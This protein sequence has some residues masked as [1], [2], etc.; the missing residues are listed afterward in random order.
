[1][2]KDI[3]WSG[4]VWVGECFFWC[5]LIWV[6]P[7]KWLLNS[8]VFV[9]FQLWTH[10]CFYGTGSPVFRVNLVCPANNARAL[11][12]TQNTDPISG[13][14]DLSLWIFLSIIGLARW[15][16]AAFALCCQHCVISNIYWE[17]KCQNCYT[18]CSRAVQAD[19]VVSAVNKV[20]KIDN[21]VPHCDLLAASGNSPFDSQYLTV[22]LCS[23]L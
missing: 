13:F 12:E 9:C 20:V 15:G 3:W 10:K 21:F 17:G 14:T 5:W 11:N 19:I 22:T 4:W 1:M 23:V 2:I 8:C 18:I 16:V 7:D 6:V